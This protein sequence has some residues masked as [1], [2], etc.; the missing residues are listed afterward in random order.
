ME[1]MTQRIEPF[2]LSK[3]TKKWINELNLFWVWRKE[4]NPFSKMTHIIEPLF[5]WTFF[6][7]THRIELI[8]QYDSKNFF[9]MTRIDF[10]Q[11]FK[12]FNVWKRILTQRLEPF[13]LNMTQIIEPF[14]HDS[15]NWT[16]F[17]TVWIKDLN[18]VFSTWLKSWI[19]VIMTQKNWISFLKFESQNWT[20]FDKMTRRIVTFFQYDSKNWTF[21]IL[22]SMTQRINLLFTWLKEL[23]LL[24][25]WKNFDCPEVNLLKILT[26]RISP[27]S[28]IQRVDFFF[29]EKNWTQRIETF[30]D[31][32]QKIE[33][34]LNTTQRIELFSQYD[35]KNWTL[36]KDDSQ[37]WTIFAKKWLKESNPFSFQKTNMI[38]RIEPFRQIWFTLRIQHFWTFSYD[39][40]NWT[41]FYM[42]QRLEPSFFFSKMLTFKNRAFF[43]MTQ[44]IEPFFST[45]QRIEL[46]SWN[47]DSQ[48]WTF[49]LEKTTQRI[50]LFYLD[51]K[52]CTFSIWLKE[53]NLF[54]MTQNLSCFFFEKKDFQR[55]EA[56]WQRRLKELN[57]FCLIQRIN[58]FYC[59]F[60][61]ID[62][63]KMIQRIEYDS[64][65]WTSFSNLTQKNWTSFQLWLKK[66][67]LFPIWLELNLFPI[68]LRRIEPLFWY[69]TQKNWTPL[70]M[71]M[72]QKFGSLNMTL[73]IDFSLW[74]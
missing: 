2:F 34:F 57:F 20:L 72:A 45:T 7:M 17:R 42:T 46:F 13:F 29:F 33:F 70:F 37:N 11:W 60:Q 5:L 44:R 26:Q 63:F 23:S 22:K 74:L 41:Y 69:M 56:F 48:N 3:K 53:L 14:L 24:F 21:P 30:C 58:L 62:F 68:W 27:F 36:L 66:L 51:S 50:E 12:E 4:Q 40:K 39:S 59:D 65:D 49:F 31:M 25:F 18:F 1:N 52:N 54:Y 47:N 15:K 38:L 73:G 8:F 43:S 10:W 28:L 9:H 67:N 71:N 19:F 16:F 55:I 32:T 35:S 6:D 61:K 64:K